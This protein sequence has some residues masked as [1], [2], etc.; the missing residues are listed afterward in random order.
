MK[1]F[2]LDLMTELHIRWEFIKQW[3]ED[4]FG[5]KPPTGMV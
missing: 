2:Y 3:F 4:T 1:N 5:P